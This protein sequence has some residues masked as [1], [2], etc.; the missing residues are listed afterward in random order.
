MSFSYNVIMIRKRKWGLLIFIFAAILL[1]FEYWFVNFSNTHFDPLMINK[2]FIYFGIGFSVLAILLAHLSYPRVHNMK[3]F[4]SGYLTGLSVLIF[5]TFTKSGIFNTV[6]TNEFIPLL[7]LFLF[8]MLFFA[9]I[10]P[11]ISKFSIV[12]WFTIFAILLEILIVIIIRSTN[13]TL[14]HLVSLRNLV[15]FQLFQ[16]I[17]GIVFIVLIIISIAFSKNQFYIGGTIGGLVLL[18]GGS[19]YLGPFSHNPALSDTYVFAITP[20]FLSLGILV[21]WIARMGH[22]AFYDPLLRIY[23]RSYCDK[24][25]S[26][27]V[28]ISTTPP[29]GIAIIDIDFFKKVNDTYGHPFG[30][31]VLIHIAHLLSNELV[32]K[33][34]LCRYGGEEF[35]V[36]FPNKGKKDLLSIMEKIRIKIMKSVIYYNKKKVKVTI[37][38]GISVRRSKHQSL[39]DILKSADKALYTAKSKGRNRVICRNL[40][41]NH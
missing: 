27:R 30:D 25:L 5:F 7:Y 15:D 6:L 23:N 39:G 9:I 14:S 18:L 2:V 8:I 38:I 16:I 10:L 36:F 20:F 22:M 41:I 19:W 33:G 3:I 34:T 32:P 11:S 28:N 31:K 12:K 24:I 40:I 17:P 29:F 26:E 1:I 35:V 13:T 4:L 37:S 21:H